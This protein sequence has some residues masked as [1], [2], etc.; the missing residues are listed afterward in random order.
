MNNA[1]TGFT[2][3]ATNSQHSIIIARAQ[4]KAGLVNYL[5][6]GFASALFQ[7]P[8]RLKFT[9]EQL[10]PMTGFYLLGNGYRSFS[11]TLGRFVS[12]DTVSPF[13]K[14]GLNSYAY[15]NGDPVNLVDPEGRAGRP[16]P[17]V[18]TAQRVL[19]RA[20]QR[21]R[22]T[23]NRAASRRHAAPAPSAGQDPA[24]LQA[25]VALQANAAQHAINVGGAPAAVPSPRD[26]LDNYVISSIKLLQANRKGFGNPQS[27]H[28]ADYQRLRN[29][30][31]TFAASHNQMLAEV[32][33]EYMSGLTRGLL[34][35][36]DGALTINT[37]KIRTDE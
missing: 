10:D 14:G 27:P 8:M 37:M 5:P 17:L 6:Y 28:Y 19:R 4:G 13:G 26:M 16:N 7:M 12:P 3:L 9:G 2:L 11:P 22:H 21:T 32:L 34:H 31:Q 30:V 25:P 35:H 29:H 33:P 23:P 36:A 24:P 20:I 15:C 1:T 18:R